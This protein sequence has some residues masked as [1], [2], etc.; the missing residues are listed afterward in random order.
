M[1]GKFH[2]IKLWHHEIFSLYMAISFTQNPI[3]LET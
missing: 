1:K 3:L 2:G